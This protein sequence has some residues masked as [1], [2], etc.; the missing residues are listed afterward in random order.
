M[1]VL[2]VVLTGPPRSGT[3]LTCHLLNKLPDTVALHEPLKIA[4]LAK[5]GT[6]AQICEV[7]ADFFLSTRASLHA[8]SLA[9]S[10]HIDGKIPDNPYANHFGAAEFRERQVTRG[11]VI[12]DKTL[13]PE[14]LLALKHPAAFTA[15]LPELIHRFRCLAIIRNPLAALASWYTVDEPM[16]EGRAPA[17]ERLEPA[18][19]K[20]L[21]HLPDRLDRQLHLLSWYYEKFS[22]YLKPADLLRYED[23]VATNGQALQMLTPHARHLTEALENRNRNRLYDDT[24][25]QTLGE[26]LLQSE[27]AYWQYYSKDSVAALLEPRV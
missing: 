14:F 22:R 23:L 24:L 16:R 27:G 12:I 8:H 17:A 25:M 2:N 13:S 18:L 11:E 7:I 19:K 1:N 15:L 4:G 5:R 9:H 21:E 3:T 6:H 10:K 26:R 20:A